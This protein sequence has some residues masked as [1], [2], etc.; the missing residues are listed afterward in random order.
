MSKN[1][2]KLNR[3]SGGSTKMFPISNSKKS[4]RKI[5]KNMK[6]MFSFFGSPIGLKSFKKNK[7]KRHVL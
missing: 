2:L 7:S 4:Q 6:D 1:K 3:G 5:K